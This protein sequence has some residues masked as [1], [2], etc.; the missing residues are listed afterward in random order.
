MNWF[1]AYFDFFGKAVELNTNSQ[2]L[3]SFLLKDY[4]FFITEKISAKPTLI[5]IFIKQR[6]YLLDKFLLKFSLKIQSLLSDQYI[7]IHGAALAK[8]GKA[9]AFWGAPGSGKSTISAFA[10]QRGYDLLSDEI[11]L[12]NRKR[13]TI[14]PFPRTPIMKI[15]PLTYNFLKEYGLS[16]YSQTRMKHKNKTYF[17]GGVNSKD[18]SEM[19]IVI[20][21][22]ESQLEKIFMFKKNGA[23]LM[24]TLL[25]LCYYYKFR[26]PSELTADLKLILFLLE[27]YLDQSISPF[28]LNSAQQRKLTYK[29]ITKLLGL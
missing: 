5:R 18:L 14:A 29:K 15:H 11:C 12:I 2:R 4:Q 17:R 10:G 3:F 22:K 23:S 1:K 13:L 21:N 28:R 27:K 24:E 25:P 8:D 6:D 9:K 20:T 16:V 19:N 7:M 26:N